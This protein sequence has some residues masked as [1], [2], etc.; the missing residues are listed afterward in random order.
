MRKRVPSFLLPKMRKIQGIHHAKI[1][2]NM[3]NYA[4]LQ[5]EITMEISGFWAVIIAAFGLISTTILIVKNLL[6]LKDRSNVPEIKQNE[7]IDSLE[8]SQQA[9]A[10]EIRSIVA[11]FDERCAKYDEYFSKDRERIDSI[12]R[13]A[14]QANTIIIKSLR[15]LI[16]NAIDGNNI[17]SLK[18]SE[19]ELDDYLFNR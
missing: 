4:C 13:N 18:A 5:G 1:Y 10:N 9:M 3:R 11:K 14:R 17:D 12:E 7:R 6:D 2:K 16:K 19:T 8:E 15:S